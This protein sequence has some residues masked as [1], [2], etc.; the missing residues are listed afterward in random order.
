MAL[1]GELEM[2]VVIFEN[3]TYLHNDVDQ[4]R[5]PMEMSRK[6]GCKGYSPAHQYKPQELYLL[7]SMVSE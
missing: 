7:Q 3:V 5:D 6:R 4:G 1:L 2:L